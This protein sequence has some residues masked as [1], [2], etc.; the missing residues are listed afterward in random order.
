MAPN[1]RDHLAAMSN[2]CEQ[3]LGA[4]DQVHPVVRGKVAVA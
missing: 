4:A 2:A 3:A 1:A